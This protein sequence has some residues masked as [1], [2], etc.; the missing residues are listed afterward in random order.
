MD[1]VSL[2]TGYTPTKTK[3]PWTAI[4][5]A[6]VVS[7]ALVLLTLAGFSILIHAICDAM[8]A[9]ISQGFFVR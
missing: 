9:P 8:L 4:T 7:S 2:I 1:T 6:L 3:I 5:V